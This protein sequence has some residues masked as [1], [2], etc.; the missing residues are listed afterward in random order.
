[1]KKCILDHEA[2]AQS[3]SQLR[4]EDRVLFRT[5]LSG[6]ADQI[7]KL[8]SDAAANFARADTDINDS[9]VEEYAKKRDFSARSLSVLARYMKPEDVAATKRKQAVEE[10]R[11]ER[12]EA[13]RTAALD[14]L[15]SLNKIK[16]PTRQ[17]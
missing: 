8:Q 15:L 14:Q 2:K 3:L 5:A 1:V 16:W 13:Y 6:L 10:L 17:Q 11:S 4:T 9:N 7:T 12:L